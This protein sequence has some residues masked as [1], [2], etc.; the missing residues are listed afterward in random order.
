MEIFTIDEISFHPGKIAGQLHIQDLKLVQRLAANVGA[1]IQPKAFYGIGYVDEKEDDSVVI[2][3]IRFHSRVLC[4]NLKGIGRVFPF[5]Q[6]LGGAVDELIQNEGD[7][8][9]QYTMD[10]LGNI[11]LRQCRCRLED[12]LRKQFALEKI[13]C[14]SPG[15]LEDWPIEDQKPL[16]RLLGTVERAIGV[17]LSDT[18]LMLPRKS[19]SGI[20]FPSEVSFYSCQLCPRENCDSRK[21]KYD[22]QKVREYGLIEE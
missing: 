7:L 12:H 2:E 5:V 4:H 10:Q 22:E 1:I 15:S 6:T 9:A 21:T 18:F 3:G 14:M 19:V 13:S 20:Y 11:A 8:L 16:F 17:Q